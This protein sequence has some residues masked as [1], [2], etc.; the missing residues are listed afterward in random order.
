MIEAGN[1]EETHVPDGSVTPAFGRIGAVGLET[2]LRLDRV[3]RGKQPVPLRDREF[4]LPAMALRV[5]GDE[6]VGHFML[7][8]RGRLEAAAAHLRNIGHRLL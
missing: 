4:R 3:G 8:G 2:A 7:V 6:G 1:P 5:G